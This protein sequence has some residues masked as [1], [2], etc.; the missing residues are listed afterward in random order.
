MILLGVD[1]GLLR[2]GYGVI[3]AKGSSMRLK[4][5]GII[6]GG[7]SSTPL[8]ERLATLYKGINE[9]MFEYSP[10][11]LALEEIYSHYAYPNTA[12]LM[13]H[14]RGVVCLAAA[15]N[16]IPVFNYAAT[17]V[18]STLAGSGRARKMQV[19]KAVT[20]RLHLPQIPEPNDV[21]DALALAIC[22][23]QIAATENKIL[24]GLK[25]R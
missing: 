23:W 12:V 8:E 18:K 10:E 19:Q 20:A 21:A 13:G 14:A 15:Q 17:R 4:E 9:V 7:P 3:E 22:H 24:R 5:G 1:P 16:G 6:Q 11:V 2:M 25:V